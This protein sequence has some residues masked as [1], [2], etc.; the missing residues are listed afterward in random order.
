MANTLSICKHYLVAGCCYVRLF[1]V[2]LKP[3]YLNAHLQ[4]RFLFGFEILYVGT[5]TRYVHKFTPGYV[6]NAGLPDL[7]TK[8]TN[9][10]LFGRTFEW[11]ILVNVLNGHLMF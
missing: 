6:H 7:H 1:M 4:S 3:I 5:Y 11:K 8:N 2:C 10:G 9:L